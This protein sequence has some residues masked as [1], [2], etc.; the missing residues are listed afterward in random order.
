MAALKR[1]ASDCSQPLSGVVVVGDSITDFK[2]LQ[3]VNQAGGLAIAFNANEYALPYATLS[4]ASTHLSDLSIVLDVWEGGGRE[5][6]K[7]VVKDR[8]RLGGTGDRENFHWVEDLKDLKAPLEIHRR[9]RRLVREEAA[10]L[11]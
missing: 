11:G 2:M 4:L 3:A 9:I 5:A 8:K 7:E 10:K 6:V 1:F